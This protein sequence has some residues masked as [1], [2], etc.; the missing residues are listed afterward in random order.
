MWNCSNGKCVGT[1]LRDSVV[2]S[3]LSCMY[4][5]GPPDVHLLPRLLSGPGAGQVQGPLAPPEQ[6]PL[7]D[8]GRPPDPGQR[9][10]GQPRA[11]GP[12]HLL[13]RQGQGQDPQ[14]A[15]GIGAGPV[16]QYCPLSSF[17]RHITM[18]NLVAFN[19]HVLTQTEIYEGT[20]HL[21]I[22]TFWFHVTMQCNATNINWIT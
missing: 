9:L 2:Y 18:H 10:G 11:P 3:C 19:E 21:K 17:S 16:I 7:P 13:Q 20:L 8:A 22:T 1:L 4:T 5:V 15:G 14:E 6:P 12:H